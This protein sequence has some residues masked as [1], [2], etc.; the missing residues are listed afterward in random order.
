MS[1]RQSEDRA[2]VADVLVPVAVEQPYSYRIPAGMALA[3]GDFVKVSLGSRAQIGVVWAVRGGASDKLKPVLERLDLPP[4]REQFRSFLDWVASWTMAPRGMVLRMATRAAEDA[5]EEPLRIGI[6]ATGAP[7]KRPT[8]ARARVLAALLGDLATTKTEL[9]RFAG[10]SAG[11]VDALIDDGALEAF[12]LPP[13]TPGGRPDFDFC[14]PALSPAQQ[15]AAR[16]LR[17]AVASRAFKPILLE[18][19]TGAGKTEVYF[20]AVAE[21]LESAG[22][23]LI[24]MP[25]IALTAQFLERFAKRFGQPPAEW[26]SGLSPRRRARVWRGAAEGEA[27]VVAGARSA[28]FLPFADLRLIVVD[29]E[30]EA[31]YKQD[32]GVIYHARDMAVVRAKS[33]SCAIVL[34]SATPSIETRENARQGRYGWQ[35][36]ESR[37]AGRTLPKIEA[38]DLRRQGPPRGKWIAPRL[39]DAM[40]QNFAQNEQALLFLNRRGYAPLTLCR[41]C[42]H[43]FQCPNCSAWLVEHR[44]RRALVC[45]HCG[46]VERRPDKCPACE[47]ADSLVACGPG[48][49]RL[50]EEAAE[51]FPEVRLLV[52]SSDMPGGT[53]RMRAELQAIENG[54]FDLVIGTQLVAKGHHFPHLTLVGVVD[55]DIGLANGDPRAAERTF[56]LLNQ[57]AGRAGRGERPGR[58]FLQT[59]QMDHPVLRALLSGDFERF[60]REETDIRREAGLPPFGRLAALIVSAADRTAAERHARDLARAAR[61]FQAGADSPASDIV[62]LGPAEAPIAVLRGKSRFRLLVKAPRAADLQGFLRALLTLAPKP[63]GGVRVIVDID[64]QNFL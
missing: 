61:Q 2:G 63:R 53:A 6:R 38:I 33:D 48:V 29:E 45:H 34:A 44:A 11:V 4:L 39:A 32:D 21:A 54:E 56:Q 12:A 30:H 9:A 52:L 28:L 51:L 18:G 24:L 26:H 55:A 64:P 19:V 43:R 35:K 23:A 8:P 15:Q 22:Q 60:Y 25:E 31:A 41:A 10:V 40:R 13:E 27:R 1:E 58:A 36:L 62:T 16:N 42:G 17:E 57:V 50:A 7:P 5:E 14:A 59:W 3:A 20:E 47:T 49:E 46:H 37:F